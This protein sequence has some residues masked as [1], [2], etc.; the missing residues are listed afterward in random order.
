EE[1]DDLAIHHLMERIPIEAVRVS[2]ALT[3][4]DRQ[5][6]GKAGYEG[7]V[8]RTL[9]KNAFRLSQRPPQ[10]FGR[11]PHA[12]EVVLLRNIDTHGNH[13]LRQRIVSEARRVRRHEHD[14]PYPRIAEF[15]DVADV[16]VSFPSGSA[17]VAA[18]LGVVG[19]LAAMR[20][21][22]A[23]TGLGAGDC[24]RGVATIRMAHHPDA[25]ALDVRPELSVFQDWVVFQ[26][27]R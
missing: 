23:G 16:A 22:C 12:R 25:F 14:G 27:W 18:E 6:H 24:Q 13:D 9:D 15:G 4:D 8:P 20:G 3:G 11:I 21:D 5:R 17:T 1:S 26:K 7:E 19:M 2:R 10:E